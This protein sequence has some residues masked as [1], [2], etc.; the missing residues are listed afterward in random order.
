MYGSFMAWQLRKYPIHK[1]PTGNSVKEIAG[2]GV[3]ELKWRR[4]LHLNIIMPRGVKAERP[5]PAESVE[6]RALIG[7]CV[8]VESAYFLTA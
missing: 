6:V 2:S 1:V 5:V 8:S 3:W 4:Q 7:C